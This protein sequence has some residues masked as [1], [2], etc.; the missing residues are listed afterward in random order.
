MKGCRWLKTEASSAPL[1][2]RSDV[3]AW[4][5]FHQDGRVIPYHAHIDSMLY[6]HSCT[7]LQTCRQHRALPS[8]CVPGTCQVLRAESPCYMS[9]TA[10]SSMSTRLHLTSALL[11]QLRL[12]SRREVGTDG[13]QLGEEVRAICGAR[14]RIGAGLSRPEAAF[15]AHARSRQ[16]SRLN[17]PT[18]QNRGVVSHASSRDGGLKRLA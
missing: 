11:L 8:P 13:L 15:S 16:V 12:Q 1:T 6:Q 7:S 10:V 14:S 18:A 4:S 17:C 3:M 9:S 5:D 2:L